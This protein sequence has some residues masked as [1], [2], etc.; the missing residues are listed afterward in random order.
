MK[1]LYLT[2]TEY[3]RFGEEII[4]DLASYNI[5]VIEN[6]HITKASRIDDKKK[7]GNMSHSKTNTKFRRECEG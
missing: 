5:K 3:K 4:K 1:Y 7:S 2:P 6:T